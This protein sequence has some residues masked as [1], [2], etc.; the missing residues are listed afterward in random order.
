MLSKRKRKEKVLSINKTCSENCKKDDVVCPKL[1]ENEDIFL[2]KISLWMRAIFN[3]V[4]W[5]LLANNVQIGSSVFMALILT[6]GPL[7][8]DYIRFRPNNIFRAF[9]R[10]TGLLLSG[11]WIIV[12][13]L[14]LNNIVSLSLKGKDFIFVLGETFLLAS[15]Q[16]VSFVHVWELLGVSVALTF[17]DIFANITKFEKAITNAETMAG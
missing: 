2:G 6:F 4:A 13:L 3:L 12:G 9:I 16:G 17:I 1:L 7:L 11:V 10:Y 14:G 8:I 5:I 15:E